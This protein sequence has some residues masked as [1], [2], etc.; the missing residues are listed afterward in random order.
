VS[1][2]AMLGYLR[3]VKEAIQQPVTTADNYEVWI[4][5]GKALS[6]I[7]DF[8]GVHTYPLWEGRSVDQG[9]DYTLENLRAVREAN[10]S[11]PLVIAEAGWATVAREFPEL[12]GEAE[13]VRYYE[14]LMGWAAEKNV[15]TFFFEAFDEDWK[16]DD[17]PDGVEKHWGLFTIDRRP[18]PV[19]R[20]L[21]G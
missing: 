6:E 4:E 14:E 8:A 2:E 21:Y 16:G 9:L 12:A 17:E 15:T 11:L 5:K 10:P 13:Q 20:A 18:K 1:L 19:M 3:Q 7:V